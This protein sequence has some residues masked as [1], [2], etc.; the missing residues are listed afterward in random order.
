MPAAVILE[1]YPPRRLKDPRRQIVL[2]AIQTEVLS[3]SIDLVFLKK[4]VARDILGNGERITR[5]NLA[6]Y[7][8]L[9]FPELTW[10]VPEERK[11]WQSEQHNMAVFNA[12]S[13]ALAYWKLQNPALQK[14]DYKRI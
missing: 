6:A 8:V 2:E 13:L 7:T 4:N 12:I 9:L 5:Q 1:I 10:K 14:G 11:P 3:K